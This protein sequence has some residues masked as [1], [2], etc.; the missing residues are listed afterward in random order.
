VVGDVSTER[1]MVQK[2]ATQELIPIDLTKEGQIAGVVAAVD[3]EEL[4]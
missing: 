2:G 1:I 3:F 4:V